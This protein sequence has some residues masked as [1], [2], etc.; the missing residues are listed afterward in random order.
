MAALHTCTLAELKALLTQAE[1]AAVPRVVLGLTIG[2]GGM[3]PEQQAQVDAWLTDKLTEQTDKVVSAVN[4]C[5]RNPKIASG[6]RKV[7]AACRYTALVLARHA[8]IS[9][10]PA[11]SNNLEGSSRAAEYQ[12]ATRSLDKLASCELFVDDYGD[13]E[14]PDIISG[15]GGVAII[16]PEPAQDWRW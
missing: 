7:P 11:Q 16:N 1:L 12:T 3:T 4:A 6:V 9:A 15:G 2:Q 8:V 13:S 14:D 5:E 10:V